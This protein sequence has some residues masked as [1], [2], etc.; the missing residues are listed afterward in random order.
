MNEQKTPTLR[1]KLQQLVDGLTPDEGAQMRSV[2]PVGSWNELSPLLQRRLRRFVD[3][4]SPEEDTQLRLL[5][6]SAADAA[7]GDQ[8]DV[9][10]HMTPLYDDGQGY[11]GRP[12]PTEGAGGGGAVLAQKYQE[13]RDLFFTVVSVLGNPPLHNPF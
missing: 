13:Q 3:E 8:A 4:L 1:A 10:G 9:A 5:Q 2:L 7:T 6:R 11:K 12:R